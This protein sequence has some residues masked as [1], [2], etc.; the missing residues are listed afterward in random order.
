MEA[1]TFTVQEKLK[2]WAWEL[3]NDPEVLADFIAKW[4]ET[5]NRAEKQIEAELAPRAHLRSW[6]Q[7]MD[8]PY[9][10]KRREK[11]VWGPRRE[12]ENLKKRLAELRKQA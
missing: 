6:E 4:E 1:S 10:M 8:A 12:L 3:E 9:W 5:I 7:P 11:E 2:H